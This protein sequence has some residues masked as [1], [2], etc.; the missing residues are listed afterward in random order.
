MYKVSKWNVKTL[1][2]FACFSCF[3][4]IK[5]LEKDTGVPKIVSGCIVMSFVLF[6]ILSG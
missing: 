5:I 2:I 6:E 4:Q 3:L 1:P